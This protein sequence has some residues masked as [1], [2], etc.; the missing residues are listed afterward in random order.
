M[1]DIRLKSLQAEF[2]LNDVMYSAYVDNDVLTL[3]SKPYGPQCGIAIHNRMNG[4]TQWYVNHSCGAHGFDPMQGDNCY[5]CDEGSFHKYDPENPNHRINSQYNEDL[6]RIIGILSKLP[7]S[8]A[9]ELNEDE[10]FKPGV[11][12]E[13]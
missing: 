10:N 1:K 2:T 12:F 5:S 7:I 9:G 11:V 6:E 3:Y 8:L 13:D 4:E